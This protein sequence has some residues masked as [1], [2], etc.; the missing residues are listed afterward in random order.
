MDLKSRSKYYEILIGILLLGV[1]FGRNMIVGGM[2]GLTDMLITFISLYVIFFG[3]GSTKFFLPP[4]IYLGILIGGYQIEFIF[5]QI[6]GLEVWLAD[7]MAN[8]MVMVGA[9]INTIGNTVTIYGNEIYALRIDGPCTGIKGIT[10]YGALAAMLV[11]DAKSSINRRM[12]AVF[13]GFVGTFLINLGRLAAI[14]LS[15]YFISVEVALLIH[16]YLGYTLFITWVIIFWSLAFRYILSK[17]DTPPIETAV[18]SKYLG[19]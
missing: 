3:I 15:S 17:S 9:E 19:K 13:L 8:I 7:V 12:F 6:K 1:N 5:P 2:F 14:F 18:S 11:I 10:A 16:T 4:S